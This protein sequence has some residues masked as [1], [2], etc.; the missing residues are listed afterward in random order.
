MNRT[1]FLAMR[2]AITALLMLAPIAALSASDFGEPAPDFARRVLAMHNQ[3]R[4]R[5]G[6]APL[7]WNMRLSQEAQQWANILVRCGAFEHSQVQDTGENLWMGTAGFYSPEQ[8]VGDFL[9]ERRAFHPGRF[10]N[11]STSGNWSDVGHYTQVIWPQTQDV[12][13]AIARGRG[14]DV[15]VCRYWP[16]GNVDGESVGLVQN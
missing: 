10:P 14:E 9:S 12:G 11:V 7:S 6:L 2:G 1:F 8:M 15:M 4:M 5:L 3:E 16:A 13:C